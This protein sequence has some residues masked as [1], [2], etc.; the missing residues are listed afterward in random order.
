MKTKYENCTRIHENYENRKIHPNKKGYLFYLDEFSGFHGFRGSVCSFHIW[1]SPVFTGFHKTQGRSTKSQVWP[2][3]CHIGHGIVFW[4]WKWL[5]S[6]SVGSAAPNEKQG[7]V[8]CGSKRMSTCA[9]ILSHPVGKKCRTYEVWN[10]RA[11]S[12][13][14]N[15]CS[16]LKSFQV[17]QRRAN[18][19]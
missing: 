16:M 9:K 17:F 1:F 10:L 7:R 14:N 11:L 13:K 15:Q 19:Q 3:G 6:I 5:P 8:N 2:S 18:P 12:D 4:P